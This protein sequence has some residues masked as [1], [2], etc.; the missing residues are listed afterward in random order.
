VRFTDEHGLEDPWGS[1]FRGAQRATGESASLPELY[2]PRTRL[3]LGRARA[4]WVFGGMGSWNDLGFA[5]H[6]PETRE[7]GA[8]T[9]ELYAAVV[10]GAATA[11]SAPHAG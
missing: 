1:M 4:A 9:D 8:L 6:T 11:V 10:G 5:G 3:L 7:Y 2:G